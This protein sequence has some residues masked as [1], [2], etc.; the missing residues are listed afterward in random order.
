MAKIELFTSPTCPYCPGAKK[1]A[2]Q[3]T[4]ELNNQKENSVE[5]EEYDT[6]TETGGSK[7]S[8][9]GIMAVPSIYVSGSA[10]KEKILFEGAPAK[11][12][13]LAAVEMADGKRALEKPKSF[14]KKLFG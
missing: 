11:K 7:A 2:A 8:E 9:Y 12:D 10:I 4:A 5:F 1:V 13:L 14:W 3:V 6:Y